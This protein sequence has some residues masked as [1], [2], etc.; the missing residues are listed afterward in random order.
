MNFLK[1]HS[2]TEISKPELYN[3]ITQN[4]KDITVTN[5]LTFEEAYAKLE[6]AVKTLEAGG[7]TLEEATALFEDG[8]KLARVCHQLLSTAELKITKLQ[9]SLSD[10]IS[11]PNQDESNG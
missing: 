7:T 4:T 11:T 5:Q 9:R 8:M 6:E 2:K 10:Q 1:L 3:S